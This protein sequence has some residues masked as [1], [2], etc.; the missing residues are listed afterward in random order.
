MAT[1]FFVSDLH[2]QFDRYR[3]LFRLIAAERPRAVFLGGDLLPSG[4]TALESL[5]ID[6]Q[7]FVNGFLARQF[8]R[9]REDLGDD[10]P[11]VFVI[12][13]NDDSR[14]EEATVIAAAATGV[15]Q[16]V[17]DR[18]VAFDGHEVYGYAC[19]PPTPFLQKDWERYDV[20]RY[21]PPGC[22][23]PEHGYHSIPVA[24]HQLRYAT[25]KNDLDTL[26]GDR[27]LDQA[28]LLF[29]SPPYDTSLDRAALDGRMIDHAPLDVH[30]GSVAIQRFIETRQPLITLHGHVHESAGITGRWSQRLGR[31]HCYTA[32]H[33][34]PELALV[35]FDPGQPARAERLLL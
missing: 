19:V 11:R 3:T 4:L 2:G 32:A 14:S 28:I 31:T 29:H 26:A 17:H 34:G 35:R 27:P 33:D 30:V 25:I 13:G 12:L 7:D 5:D 24:E 10:Y 18:R 15:W 1:C 6:H 23:S 21:V 20:S 8:R 9:L 16:Y 22:V